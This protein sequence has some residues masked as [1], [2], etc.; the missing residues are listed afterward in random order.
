MPDDRWEDAAAYDRFMGRWSRPLARELVSWLGVPRAASWLEVGCGT[1]ALTAAICEEGNPGSVVACDRA[2][3]FVAYCRAHLR[4]PELQFVVTPDGTL[5]VSAQGYDAV[6]SSLVLNFLPD[7]VQALAQ[8]RD[9]CAPRGSVAAC[10]WDYSDGMEFLRVF[11]DVAVLL[12]PG[13]RS[14]HEGHRFPV[15][16]ADTLRSAF[17]GAGLASVEVEPLVV[18]TPF[19][20]FADYWAPF[21]D[22]PGPAPTYVSTLSAAARQSL[23]DRLRAGLFGGSDGPVT[24]HARAWAAKGVRAA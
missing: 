11:W 15:C 13:A 23:A 5:P 8:M 9:A 19:A 6:V 7:P 4:Y 18:S 22:G 16:H 20:D 17:V 2:E 3:D 10:V 24:L 21:V 12:D 14:L 1:G